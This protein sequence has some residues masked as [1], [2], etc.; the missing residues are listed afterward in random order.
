MDPVS[1]SGWLVAALLAVAL[2]ARPR[3]RRKPHA[4]PVTP[5]ARAAWKAW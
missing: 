3:R 2:L 5:A 4:H 1:V